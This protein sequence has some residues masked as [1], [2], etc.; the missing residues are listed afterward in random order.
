MLAHKKKA[1]CVGIVSFG[2]VPHIA[3]Q[4]IARQIRESLHIPT[5]ILPPGAP[6]NYAYDA[7]RMQYNAATILHHFES[8]PFKHHTKV[9][10]IVNVDLFIPIFT[11]VFGE[12]RE[13]GKCAVVSLYRLR[14]N[15]D[16]SS[17]SEALIL[18]RLL[19]VTLHE[20]GH[21]FDVVHCYDTEC[22]MHF[23]GRLDQLDELPLHFCHY[24]N[25]YLTASIRRDGIS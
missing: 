23:S 16:G 11:H 1:G 3:E 13:G 15:A 6:P 5:E 17:P 21:L 8:I 7:G 25:E 9:V 22:L 14:V 2:S 18:E 24:C 4:M 10:G 12:A 20:I 19:K